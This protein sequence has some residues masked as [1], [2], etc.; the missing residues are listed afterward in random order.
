MTKTSRNHTNLFLSLLFLFLL[1]SNC[2]AA[3]ELTLTPRV[4]E[5]SDPYTLGDIAVARF[6][7]YGILDNNMRTPTEAAH[8]TFSRI[9]AVKL[10]QNTFAKES[11]ATGSIPFEDVRPNDKEAVAWAYANGIVNGISEKQF[12]TANITE[13]EFVT[14][15]LGAMGYRGR[16]SFANA[17]TYAQS[18]GLVPLEVSDPFTLCDAALYLQTAMD[19]TGPDGEK[20]RDKMNIPDTLAQTSF[21]D[22]IRL[23]PLTV[24]DAERQIQEAVRYLPSRIDVMTE[25]LTQ[26]DGHSVYIGYL[27]DAIE[28]EKNSYAG[29]K[30][31]APCLDDYSVISPILHFHSG[32]P[33]PRMT[34][35]L[36][37]NNAWELTCDL[38]NA[39]SY[40]ENDTL[41][42]LADSFYREYVAG[43]ANEKETI[44]KA[45]RAIVARAR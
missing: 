16:F 1:S 24:K 31:Y 4:K 33:E 40:F 7:V 29:E 3:S 25:H 37:Y 41:T 28:L 20:I 30:W 34:L 11:D 44:L 26:E 21:P 17:L 10:L 45:K 35:Y 22:C 9:E 5:S 38:D 2:F 43:A 42:N 15:L 39:F 19:V 13:R 8:A 12:G 36:R 32:V 23:T 27:R 18:I 14:M 6:A